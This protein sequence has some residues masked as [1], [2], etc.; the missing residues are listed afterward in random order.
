M[1]AQ[2]R[3]TLMSSSEED[4]RSRV[5]PRTRAARFLLTWARRSRWHP[6]ASPF[7]ALLAER[8]SGIR[9]ALVYG[10]AL[11]GKSTL[12]A[13]LAADVARSDGWRVGFVPLGRASGLCLESEALPILLGALWGDE[14]HLGFPS[15]ARLRRLLR[16]TLGRDRSGDEAE[17][18]L[19]LD[20]VD[21][22]VD[23]PET[24]ATFSQVGAGRFVVVTVSGALE[25]AQ[26]W[27]E[28]LGW[29]T[30]DVR[31]L[32][33]ESNP[34]HAARFYTD[35]EVNTAV[36][37][38]E[39]AAADES[40]ARI[41]DALALAYAP[42]ALDDLEPLTGIPT[43]TLTELVRR[44]AGAN[45][46]L[47]AGEGNE[48]GFS[49]D[50]YAARWRD[51][52]P[53][54]LAR[55]ER[56]WLELGAERAT[57]ARTS[58]EVAIPE[59]YLTRYFS[60]H[61][62]AVGAR[63]ESFVPLAS[64]AWCRSDSPSTTDR[65]LADLDRGRAAAEERLVRSVAG[66]NKDPDACRWIVREALAQAALWDL[67]IA[68]DLEEL[69]AEA[70]LARIACLVRL[71][72]AATQP[73]PITGDA[74]TATADAILSLALTVALKEGAAG[75]S[76]FLEAL[77]EA[78]VAVPLARGG[79]LRQAVKAFETDSEPLPAGVSLH[80]AKVI[81]EA[82]RRR[83]LLERVVA[84]ARASGSVRELLQA[85][86]LLC[87]APPSA[88]EGA[89]HG[90]A[91]TAA[92]VDVLARVGDML[93]E[94]LR[95]SPFYQAIQ[96]LD[97]IAR[98]LGPTTGA[99]LASRIVQVTH[100]LPNAELRLRVLAELIDA[101]P[102]HEREAALREGVRLLETGP[103]PGDF[104]A[105]AR[106]LRHLDAGTLRALATVDGSPALLRVIAPILAE[107]G[108]I[109]EAQRAIERIPAPDARCAALCDLADVLG[110]AGARF[111]DQARAE[112]TA[113]LPEAAEQLLQTSPQTIVRLL[114][115]P[116]ALDMARRSGPPN[117]EYVRVVALAR[118]LP[119]LPEGL[120]RE[121][122]DA[123]YRC[124]LAEP[125][126]E[127][128]DEL[129]RA[130]PWIDAPVLARIFDATLIHAAT[131]LTWSG[132]LTGWAGVAHL[133][134]W[135]ERLGGAAALETIARELVE[136][137]WFSDQNDGP[138]P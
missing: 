131:P 136:S 27:C 75:V 111:F 13:K 89:D 16:S 60:A 23:W 47:V 46:P 99:H 37:W 17:V 97:R 9:R 113:L 58:P 106:F 103:S 21:R 78:E 125:D 104:P 68:E 70:R 101:L 124:L 4:R 24:C 126:A 62:Q 55:L 59:D 84:S 74:T 73:P 42:L 31:L 127:A 108:Y 93:A 63:A 52:V 135:I 134:P 94:M 66:G 120:R 57:R 19:I 121:A 39:R 107:R 123:L 38:L 71:A 5:E 8:D 67:E 114:G 61:L 65:R 85:A 49:H 1:T 86:E 129:L 41:V 137:A 56:R 35:A 133:A 88:G 48:W 50:E 36:S 77:T 2:A 128:L 102:Q 11:S 83:H 91:D 117:G 15:T 32:P 76:A 100:A 132:A 105:L 112:A 12:V 33:A 64:P 110:P 130:T 79:A 40:A 69:R 80:L 118:L 90:G 6:A 87:D 45:G 95:E 92:S 22:C 44:F 14:D 109:E 82:E 26:L 25:Q 122:S 115:G 29:D 7:E 53:E 54:R 116:R 81:G 72:G 28:R 138:G 98:S 34:A 10:P 3:K 20:G 43:S 119:A 51:R 18:L 30:E 96:R